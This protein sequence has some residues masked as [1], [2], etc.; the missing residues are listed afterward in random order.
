M[1]NQINPNLA[2]KVTF[3]DVITVEMTL[4]HGVSEVFK[5]ITCGQNGGMSK[6]LFK[7]W[8]VL[9]K[10][11]FNKEYPTPPNFEVKCVKCKTLYRIRNHEPIT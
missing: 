3:D 1:E 9:N 4:G 6:I 8:G 2:S 10:I 11:F 5:C 7:Y